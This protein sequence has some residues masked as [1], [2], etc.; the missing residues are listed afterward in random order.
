MEEELNRVEQ[1][2]TMSGH[3]KRKLVVR[4]DS[5][6]TSDVE[7]YQETDT[8]YLHRSGEELSRNKSDGELVESRNGKEKPPVTG[9]TDEGSQIQDLS[10][11][12]TMNHWKA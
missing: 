3:D 12:S 9:Q 10:G 4:S 7:Y 2:R 11:R 6:E 8:G 1:N 5:Y